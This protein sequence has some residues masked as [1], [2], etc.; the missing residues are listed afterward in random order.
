MIDAR[1]PAEHCSDSELPAEPS[2]GLYTLRR[3]E[4]HPDGC[5]RHLIRS[6]YLGWSGWSYAFK[7]ATSSD[8]VLLATP[9]R[10]DGM[11]RRQRPAEPSDDCAIE[12]QVDRSSRG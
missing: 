5:G 7:S 4:L 11:L 12:G 8:R 10:A 3:T 6:S 9:M 2:Q 1:N